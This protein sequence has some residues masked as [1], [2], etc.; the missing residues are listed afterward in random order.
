LTRKER[1]LEQRRIEV[2]SSIAGEKQRV[3]LMALRPRGAEDT[4][5]TDLLKTVLE[6]FAI[7]EAKAKAVTLADELED[8]EDDAE[9]QGLFATYFCPANEISEEGNIAIDDIE[10]WGVP[11]TAPQKLRNRLSQKLKTGNANPHDGL[12]GRGVLYSIYAESDSW[13]DFIDDYEDAGRQV[14]A[15]V[16][17]SFLDRQ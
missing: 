12:G 5:N 6:R 11:K 14:K 15:L 7:L 8:L 4:V 16:D 10:L 17:G 1:K 2:L 9:L 3:G 13:S